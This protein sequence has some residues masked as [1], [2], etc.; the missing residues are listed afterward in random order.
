MDVTDIDELKVVLKKEYQILIS[1]KYG[2][3]ME[4]RVLTGTLVGTLMCAIIY[5]YLQKNFQV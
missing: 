2:A 5:Q 1:G 3:E 4:L